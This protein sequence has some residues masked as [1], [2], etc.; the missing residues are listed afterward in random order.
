[1]SKPSATF[2]AIIPNYNHSGYILN[3]LDAAIGQTAPFD[4]IIVIDDASTDNS[5]TLIEA[6]I[7]N[8]PCARLIR[9]A[10]NMGVIR[11]SNL[12]VK[13]ATGDFICYLS[14]DD[15]YDRHLVEWCHE[16]LR[17]YPDL[18][19]ISGN[20]RI[21]NVTT[22]T[23]HRLI[24]PFA[25]KMACY[26]GQNIEA[27]SKKR[28]FTF[29]IGANVVR[30]DAVIAAGQLIQ[31]LEWHADWFLYL[32]IACRHPFGVV[33]HEFVHVRQGGN[34]YSDACNDWKKQRP[35][36]EAFIRTL[37]KD[38]PAEYAFFRRCA[39]LPT[40]DFQALGLLW[41]EPD[42]RDYLT[43]LL[44]WRLLTYKPLRMAG[45]WMPSSL[46]AR[47]RQWLKV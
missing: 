46:R 5:V 4:E 37:R 6:R 26:S 19:M 32:V 29:N 36:I 16:M 22:G 39:L 23:Q 14:A 28:A 2:S 38:Y 10:Q 47:A 31:A 13:E 44:A 7:R 11:S 40:Y 9:N 1:M 24:L 18:G 41:R 25:Q 43:P 17:Q 12:G 15:H 33:P 35:V 34:Q 3:T 20:T 27:I 42:L 21:H 30:R 45:R 8:I